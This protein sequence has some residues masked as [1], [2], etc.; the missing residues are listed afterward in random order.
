ME[1]RV[2]VLKE[3]LDAMFPA[4]EKGERIEVRML[5][6][7][8]NKLPK[9]YFYKSKEQ[10]VAQYESLIKEG[11]DERCGVYFGVCPRT[12]YKGNKASIN[13]AHVL[14]ADLDDKNYSGGKKE[15]LSR[16]RQF[17]FK[18]TLIIDSGHGYH[19]Y[20]KLKEPQTDLKL[21][22]SYLDAVAVELGSDRAVKDVSRV[23]RLPGT[24]NNK[25]EDK[26]IP[27]MVVAIDNKAVYE[28]S[29]FAYLL[30][31][32]TDEHATL[33]K[34]G[35]EW[36]VDAI[37]GMKEGNRNT[38]FA[39][40]IGRFI[41]EDFSAQETFKLLQPLA[42][43]NKY[44]VKE[45]MGQVKEMY[46]RYPKKEGEEK[47]K[48]I[49]YVYTVYFEGLVDIV[50]SEGNP[51]FLIKDKEKLIVT[52]AMPVGNVH[53]IPPKKS[54]ITWLLPRA[55]EVIKHY[56]SDNDK[57]L[58]LDLLEY[59]KE[60]SE[61]PGEE[62]YD[63]IVAWDLHT[64]VFESFQYSP[65]IYLFA[66]PERGKSRT[67][68][69]IIYVAYRGVHI[70]SL[71][72]AYILRLASDCK[73]TLF[74]D[75]KNLWKMA[76]SHGT[77]DILLTRY[78]KG[79]KVPRVLYPER[80]PFEDTRHYD[81]FGPTI[82]ATNVGVDSILET[83]AIQINMPETCK[84]FENEVTPEKSLE[85]KERLV[86]FRA[87]HLGEK[88]PNIRKP[89]KS[90]LGDI[91]RPI[92]QIILL[93]N[94]ER[95]P[96][97]LTLVSKLEAERKIDRATSIEAEILM[98]VLSLEERV[99]D[100]ILE[101]KYVEEWLNAKRT[102]RNQL[103]SNSI[104]RRLTAMGFKRT[105]T[106][107]GHAAIVYD[108]DAIRILAERYDVNKASDSSES[109]EQSQYIANVTESSEVSED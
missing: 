57:K 11:V 40:L 41:K 100:G 63:L 23:M 16:L 62:Y 13:R 85:Y 104:G 10:L 33:V 77:E 106:S 51:A 107:D 54:S 92:Q 108:V 96:I 82:I 93:V 29:E 17:R 74:F 81:V 36:I 97:F 86:A 49:K 59:H 56:S 5:S 35:D 90:R 65:Y 83:R 102:E 2:A 75:V 1:K 87:R 37:S 46:K 25:E 103:K 69:G 61:L 53:Y 88:L 89:A 30:K 91:L 45:L 24:I 42:E 55:A 27:T 8:G 43:Q 95:E 70:Q 105:R 73:A 26:Q 109:S 50:A 38:V 99:H 6:V 71:R 44:P 52:D 22:E 66:V 21:V 68:K 48:K 4:L 14:W 94:P 12:S 15:A 80:G 3:V 84:Q 64:Y 60:I 9:R 18:P 101:N 20:W 7:K 31:E 98:A 79:V 58:Y 39:K 67:G 47:M 32:T 78:E 19:A 34:K 76:E 72:E 28:H